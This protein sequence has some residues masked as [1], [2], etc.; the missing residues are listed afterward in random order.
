MNRLP[1]VPILLRVALLP[2]L[3]HRRALRRKL[4]HLELEQIDMTVEAHRHVH[5]AVAGAVLHHNI[6]ARCREVGVEHARVVPLEPGDVVS[7]VPFIGNA[8]EERP[9][10]RL[11]L[12]ILL[13]K[14]MSRRG[15]GEGEEG[16]RQG[17]A[18]G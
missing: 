11:G 1:Q 6:K 5:P 18:V 14:W 3:L 4:H 9:E 2:E 8:G 7:G 10:Q 12:V 13:Y 17:C 16:S 15:T